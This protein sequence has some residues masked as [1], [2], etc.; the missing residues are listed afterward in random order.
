MRE[1]RRDARIP[2]RSPITV[3]TSDGTSVR[4]EII[5]LSLH[6]LAI[7]YPAPA[8]AGAVLKLEFRLLVEDHNHTFKLQGIVRYV[9]LVRNAYRIGLEFVDPTANQLEAIDRFV[10]ARIRTTRV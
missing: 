6:G 5:D 10:R 7:L 2:M 4:A 3:Y 1:K 8:N 9:H